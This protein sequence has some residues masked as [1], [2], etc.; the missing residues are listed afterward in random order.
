ME[1]C[2]QLPVL[3]LD[4]PVPQHVLSRRGAISF[5]SSSALFGCPNPRQL[6]QRRGAISYDSSDQT[7]LYIRMLGD[8]R[9]RSR[10]G[11]E[12][13]RRGSHPYIDFRIFHSNS[14][15]EVSVSARN[16]RRLLS[17]QRYLR[18]S[19]FFRGITVPNSSNILDDDYNGQ[20][21]CMLEKVGNWNFDIFLFDRLTNVMVQEDYHS[22]NPYHNAVHAADVTQAMH[23]YLKEP[24][25]SK[26]LTPWDVLLSLI[27]AATHDLDHPGVNQPFLIKTN[28]Y[29]ATL[30][31]NTS[32][33]ENHHWRSAV[34]L[35]RESGLFA[36]MS[37]ENRQLMESQIGDLILATDISQQ[38]EYLSMFRSHLDRGDLCL[39]NAN[40]R[41]FILQMA[42]KCA[43][44]CNPCRTWE[45]SKQWSE[46]V[47][48][49][50]FHQGDIEKK[51]HLGVSPLCDRQTETIANIQ[52]GF[53]TYL[54]EPLF[55]EW[56]RFSNT[57]LSQTMLG[58]LGLN[59]ASWKGVQREQSGSGDD[60]DPAFEEMDSDI[61]PQ[62][63]RLS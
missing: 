45:L 48:E 37:L 56:A 1:V 29:L 28:H 20:A 54:V 6:S 57:R 11:F 34:G 5:S 51:Y 30:Y 19:R 58:H 49:E 41:H 43:D 31:K 36:H 16:V 44:I 42:L 26:S 40:H 14:E 24:K 27:A 53:M 9:V 8:V 21:K 32:V 17:F 3:P 35:L 63:P 18:S 33:L 12:T 7:A 59:K 2:Y 47:T 25:L 50:F 62:E 10:A 61:L 39:E 15:I 55:G 23:C 22:Q 52:I 13:E 46:K 38:N 60:V 4:R